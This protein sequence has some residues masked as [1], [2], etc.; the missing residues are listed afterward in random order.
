MESSESWDGTLDGSSEDKVPWLTAVEGVIA[1]KLSDAEAGAD[2]IA[3]A[4]PTKL[5]P[6]AP[7]TGGAEVGMDLPSAKLM[8]MQLP[9]PWK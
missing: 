4:E 6:D 9:V 5:A 1:E 2:D 7:D 8:S 3:A